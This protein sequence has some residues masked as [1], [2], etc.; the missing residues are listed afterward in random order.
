MTTKPYTVLAALI[1]F[2]GVGFF[3]GTLVNK[4]TEVDTRIQTFEWSTGDTVGPTSTDNGPTTSGDVLTTPECMTTDCN[5][6]NSVDNHIYTYEVDPVYIPQILE[7]YCQGRDEGY[8][9]C[10]P[11]P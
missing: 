10:L 3:A 6:D 5:T 4:P 7:E 9:P 8:P 11:N 1:V 2:F